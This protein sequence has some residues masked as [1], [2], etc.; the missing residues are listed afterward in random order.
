MSCVENIYK[1]K[2]M[3]YFSNA[4]PREDFLRKLPNNSDAKILDIGCGVGNTGVLA[5]S[6]KKC[7]TYCGVELFESSALEAKGR[8]SQVIIGNIETLKLPW[9]ESYFDALLI[10]E[11]LEHLFDPREVLLKLKPLMKKGAFVFASSPNVAHYRFILMLLRGYW[12]YSEIGVMDWTHIRWFTPKSYKELFESCGYRVELIEPTFLTN[13]EK[14][15]NFMTCGLCEY[16]LM[17]Q[18][19]LLGRC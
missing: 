7:G 19:N 10:S 14:I 17:R 13:K 3:N 12:N 2:K 18:M 15:A 6:T 11:V 1:S 8:I 16:L 9:P 5:L 4:I